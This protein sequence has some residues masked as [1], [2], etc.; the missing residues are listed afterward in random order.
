MEVVERHIIRIGRE[1]D[2]IYLEY[3]DAQSR[4]IAYACLRS[5]D[6]VCGVPPFS[7]ALSASHA[8]LPD[9]IRSR[10]SDLSILQIHWIRK[11]VR[12][13]FDSFDRP[14]GASS[15]QIA[16]LLFSALEGGAI[17]EC[18]ANDR[19]PSASGYILLMTKLGLREKSA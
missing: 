8:C 11:V 3:G 13:H 10:A 12:D 17:L 2:D 4:L 15:T 5:E 19:E 14:S 6:F 16:K 9:A 7:V 18:A 1:L